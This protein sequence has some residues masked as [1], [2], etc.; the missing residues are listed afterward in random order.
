MPGARSKL[1][2]ALALAWGGQAVK[3]ERQLQESVRRWRQ[4]P[5]VLAGVQKHTGTLRSPWQMFSVNAPVERHVA[6]RGRL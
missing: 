2:R 4:G 1:V 3:V 6:A 5:V